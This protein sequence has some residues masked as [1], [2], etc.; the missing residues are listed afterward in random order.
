MIICLIINNESPHDADT[1]Y[2]IHTLC[3]MVKTMKANGVTVDAVLRVLRE[4][5][6]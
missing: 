6:P 3:Q 4:R 2:N 1:T 5:Q